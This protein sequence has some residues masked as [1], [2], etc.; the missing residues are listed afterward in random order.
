LRRIGMDGV[1]HQSV[2]DLVRHV[3]V[4][5]GE[6]NGFQL[7]IILT[8]RLAAALFVMPGKWHRNSIAADN[9]PLSLNTR[10]MASAVAS[11]TLNMAPAWAAEPQRTSRRPTMS[12]EETAP[13]RGLKSCRGHSTIRGSSPGW[14][15][16]ASAEMAPTRWYQIQP[17]TTHGSLAVH[18]SEA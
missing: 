9:S 4:R 13:G 3:R 10:R 14:R 18:S 12:A 2:D 1:G 16:G 6:D 5:F 8:Q 15:P 17:R 11:S 7:A